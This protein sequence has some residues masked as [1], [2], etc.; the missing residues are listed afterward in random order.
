MVNAGFALY[1][2]GSLRHCGAAVLSRRPVSCRS[3]ARRQRDRRRGSGRLWA[4]TGRICQGG[5]RMAEADALEERSA[6]AIFD[7]LATRR[8]IV[9]SGKGGVG[10]TTLAALLGV[11][12]SNRG[13]K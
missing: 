9:V 2:P 8:L 11:A 3:C 13:R 4:C 12:L 6:A 7:G 10:R 5:S 1:P